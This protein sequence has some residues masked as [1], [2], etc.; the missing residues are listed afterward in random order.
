[1]DT[2]KE[3]NENNSDISLGLKDS[4]IDI[5]ISLPINKKLSSIRYNTNKKLKK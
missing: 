5:T 1:M 3:E 4:Y 2:I